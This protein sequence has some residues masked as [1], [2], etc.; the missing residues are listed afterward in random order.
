MSEVVVKI[1]DPEL[2]NELMRTA[3]RMELSVEE[4]VTLAVRTFLAQVEL[5]LLEKRY[6]ELLEKI[7][8]MSLSLTTYSSAIINEYLKQ[9]SEVKQKV[10]ERRRIL[11]E[12]KVIEGLKEV[13]LGEKE[14]KELG[15]LILKGCDVVVFKDDVSPELLSTTVVGIY[16][17]RTIRAPRS[18]YSTL[19]LKAKLCGSIQVSE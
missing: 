15:K 12:A 1:K 13:K 18:L 8:K 11:R 14:L 3:S 5:E 7:E 2:A 9:L 16:G 10:E 6:Y 17:V 4:I 19:L